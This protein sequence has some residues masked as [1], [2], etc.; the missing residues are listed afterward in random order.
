MRTFKGIGAYQSFI[1]GSV[2]RELRLKYKNSLLGPLWLFF[3]PVIVVAVYMLVFSH[4]MRVK[5]DYFSSHYSYALYLCIGVIC[6]QFFV[7]LV[8]GVTNIFTDYANI[9]KKTAFPLLTLPLIV[10]LKCLFNFF[11]TFI[12][13]LA[14]LL[15]WGNSSALTISSFLVF[16]LII[17]VQIFLGL[18]LGLIFGTINMAFRDVSQFLG[19]SF[20]L[21]FWLTPIVYPPDFLF[22]SIQNLVTLNPMTGFILAYQNLLILHKSIHFELIIYSSVVAVSTLTFGAIFFHLFAPSFIEEL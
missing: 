13:F 6:W 22:E 5:T 17:V 11:V 20:Q 8:L 12:I 19:I 7:D 3:H 14:A 1:L 9:I 15:F 16:F 10:T 21:L 18:G 4:F 2:F